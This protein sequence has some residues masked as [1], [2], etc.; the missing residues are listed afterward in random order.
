MLLDKL[1]SDLANVRIR[2]ALIAAFVAALLSVITIMRPLDVAVWSL[3]SKLFN[4]DPS[5]EIIYVDDRA[6]SSDNSRAAINLKLL[7][8]IDELARDDVKQIVIHVP[9]QTSDLKEIDR[10]LREAL[11][12]NEDRIVLTRA[13][14][15]DIDQNQLVMD[16]SPYFERGMRIASSDI[17]PDFLGFV[18]GIEASHSDGKQAYP[19]VWNVIAAN[20]R[21]TS[22][23]STDYSIDTSEIVRFDLDALGRGELTVAAAVAG[24]TVVI[25]GFN[26]DRRSFNM[27]DASQ[28]D[29]PAALI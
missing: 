15:R 11:R 12:R 10:E 17:D 24:K 25:G 5:G 28:S 9:M 2:H 7:R 20:G 19:S 21:A 29:V 8:A 26:R 16:G 1:Q 6:P 13:M 14:R 18:W 22:A 4:H 23:I 27:P 3:Q